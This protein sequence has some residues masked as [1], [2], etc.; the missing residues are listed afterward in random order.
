[1]KPARDERLRNTHS[2]DTE[3]AAEI[4]RRIAE[5]EAG[6]AKLIPA[7][8]AIA[9]ARAKLREVSRAARRS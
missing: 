3:W 1:M 8:E 9:S 7:K 6:T 2:P 4:A 5:V